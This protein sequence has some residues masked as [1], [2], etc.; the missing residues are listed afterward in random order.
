MTTA[1]RVDL[2]LG[3]IG[4]GLI[5]VLLLIGAVA[6]LRDWHAERAYRKRLTKIVRQVKQDIADEPRD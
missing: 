1:E 4:L 2:V 5:A 6:L 3:L